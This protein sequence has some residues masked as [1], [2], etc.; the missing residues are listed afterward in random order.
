MPALAADEDAAH[1]A[2]VADP[3][4]EPAAHLLRVREVGEIGT[5][6]FTRMNDEESVPARGGEQGLDRRDRPPE[7]GYVVAERLA[8]A[9]RIDEVAL[10]VDDHQRAGARVELER[11]RL[12][13]DRRHRLVPFRRPGRPAPAALQR[14]AQTVPST[15]APSPHSAFAHTNARFGS[16]DERMVVHARPSNGAQRT[17]RRRV[18]SKLG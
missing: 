2:R 18:P 5:V 10:H 12:C 8:E 3:H 11:I 13:L 6:A 17:I 15:P 1:R 16:A 14:N 4:R 9:A 7:E